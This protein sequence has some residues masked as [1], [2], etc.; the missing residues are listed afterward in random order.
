MCT[1]VNPTSEYLLF[2]LQIYAK[3]RKDKSVTKLNDFSVPEIRHRLK[4]YFKFMT[5]RHPL[6]R[7]LS[8]WIDKFQFPKIYDKGTFEKLG[9]K[10]LSDYRPNFP[11]NFRK[12]GKGVYFNE[13]I[14]YILD[15]HHNGHWDG[16]YSLKCQPCRVDFDAIV[17]L[18][19]FG[20]DV[21][22][23]VDSRLE[24]RG[25]T[26]SKNSWAH[27]TWSKEFVKILE[28]YRNISDEQLGVLGKMYAKDF[29]LFGYSYKRQKTAELE[30]TCRM[31]NKTCC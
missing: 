26:T 31:A 7:L 24:G 29:D 27:S 30:I 10:I 1:C 11:L 8:T 13:M 14:H 9:F 3:A 21:P 4:T 19:T 6:D 18:E 20:N 12:Q 2:M 23:I 15:G 17:K 16:P 28:Q 25:G 5:V 22:P